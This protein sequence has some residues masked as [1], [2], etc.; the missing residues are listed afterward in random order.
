MQS[1]F[2]KEKGQPFVQNFYLIMN[3]AVGGW[4]LDGPGRVKFELKALDW[5]KTLEG[6]NYTCTDPW[7]EFYY[8]AAEMW[9]DWVKVW[10]LEDIEV[11]DEYDYTCKA[12]PDRSQEELCGS[13]NV[14]SNLISRKTS[15]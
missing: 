13:A 3:V 14:S 8:P 15:F 12:N 11:I 4:F 5:E 1:P 2:Y 6:Y 7:D 9:V 10:A